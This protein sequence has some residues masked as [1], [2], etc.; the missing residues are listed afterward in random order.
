VLDDN[1]QP[2]RIEIAFRPRDSKFEV[3]DAAVRRDPEFVE[4]ITDI[5]TKPNAYSIVF[6]FLSELE[7]RKTI[8]LSDRNAIAHNLGRL[9]EL[10]KYPLTALEILP[11]ADEEAVADIF[12]RTNSA[13]VK[14]NQADFI[15]TL[16]SVFWEDGRK[17]LETFSQAARTPATSGAPSPFN[18]LIRP[19]PSQLLRVAIAVG[20]HRGRLRSVYQVLRGK[21]P[22]TDRFSPALRDQQFARLR[23]AQE[24]VLDLNNW[25]DFLSLIR[26]IGFRSTEMISSKNALLYAY[27]FY[28]LGRAKFGVQLNALQRLIGM[29]FFAAALCANM[30]ETP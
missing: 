29:W 18:H 25:H 5:L 24:K 23:Q 14:L 9:F 21:D 13:G 26:N 1:F 11:S 27:A 16:L 12:V 6:D 15:L 20:F 4:N 8:S 22:D 17:T 7:T 19:E 30:T 2:V 28:V 10:R 3:T